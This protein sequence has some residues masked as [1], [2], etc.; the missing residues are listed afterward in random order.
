MYCKVAESLCLDFSQV[1]LRKRELRSGA[2]VVPIT[3]DQVICLEFV[4]PVLRALL[5]LFLWCS[6]N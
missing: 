6:V 2:K 5:L 3:L 4:K 1:R